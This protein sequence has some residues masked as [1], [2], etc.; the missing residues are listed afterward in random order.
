MND[1]P[2][3]LLGKRVVLNDTACT[4]SVDEI[5]PRPWRERLCS[6]PWRPWRPTKTVTKLVPSDSI[7]M[8]GF[9]GNTIMMHSQTWK[10]LK[11]AVEKQA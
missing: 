8:L 9:M 6:W 5:V 11:E 2:L 4:K 7:Y 3:T 10:R 1:L